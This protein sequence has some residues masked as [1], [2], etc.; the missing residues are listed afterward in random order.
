[1]IILFVLGILIGSIAVIFSLQNTA[2]IVVT[3]FSWTLTG[4]LAFIL[5]MAMGTGI[6]VTLL[7]LFPE[8]ISNYFRYKALKKENTKI[9]EELRKQKQLTVFAHQTAPTKEQLE[10]I[11]RGAIEE[12]KTE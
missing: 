4:S 8:F 2:I 7:L 9:E 1:M 3:F 5:L 10:K 11:G 6:L 12:P